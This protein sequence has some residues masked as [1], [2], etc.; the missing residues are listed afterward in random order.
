MA[1]TSSSSGVHGP[2]FSPILLQHGVG[3][4]FCRCFII[5]GD[6]KHVAMKYFFTRKLMLVKES[7]GFI[8]LPGGFGTLDE[9]LEL[10]TLQ[11]TGKS[12]PT[13]I[14]LLDVPVEVARARVAD[15]APDRLESEDAGFHERVRAGFHAQAGADPDRWAVVD[16]TASPDEIEAAVWAAVLERLPDLA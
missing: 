7:K 16:G 10:L 15:V 9:T 14:V 5:G 6:A 11:Q 8:A 3:A 4:P 1:S 12:E 2:R 13:P